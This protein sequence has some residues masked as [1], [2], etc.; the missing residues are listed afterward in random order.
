MVT[1]A[2]A[3]T[4]KTLLRLRKSQWLDAKTDL[5]H[6]CCTIEPSHSIER[7]EALQS[8]EAL[9]AHLLEFLFH[10]APVS[11]SAVGVDRVFSAYLQS[12]RMRDVPS[13]LVNSSQNRTGTWEGMNSQDSALE[14]DRGPVILWGLLCLSADLL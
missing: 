14:M 3:N 13:K 10:L 7:P 8:T 12:I 6:P 9:T 5:L 11:K 2:L 4:L 1:A